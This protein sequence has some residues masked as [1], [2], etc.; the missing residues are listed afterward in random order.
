MSRQKLRK[1]EREAQWREAQ[2]DSG[3]TSNDLSGGQEEQRE[4]IARILNIQAEEI[5]D[6]GLGY[7]AL[8]VDGGEEWIKKMWQE[9]GWSNFV[10]DERDTDFD[11]DNYSVSDSDVTDDGKSEL[12]TLD[13]TLRQLV[14]PEETLWTLEINAAAAGFF[15]VEEYLRWRI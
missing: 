11:R 2:F 10:D 6:N 8:A 13:T 3:L 4:R 12:D 14:K 7:L 9:D 5:S 1:A 15:G